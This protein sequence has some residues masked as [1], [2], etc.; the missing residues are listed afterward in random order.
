MPRQAIGKKHVWPLLDAV[1]RSYATN[2]LQKRADT[3]CRDQL[4]HRH[5]LPTL[6]PL[7]KSNKDRAPP[8]NASDIVRA[9]RDPAPR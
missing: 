1:T 4:P 8:S 5:R 9:L 2:A 3:L 7:F 6:T